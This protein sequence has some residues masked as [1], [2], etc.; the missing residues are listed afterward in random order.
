MNFPI[1][2]RPPER[3]LC[4]IQDRCRDAAAAGAGFAGETHLYNERKEGKQC[5]RKFLRI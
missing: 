3:V 5:I 2:Q 4:V 1:E